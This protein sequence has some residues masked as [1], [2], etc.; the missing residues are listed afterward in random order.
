MRKIGFL[1]P[2]FLFACS[3]APT[4]TPQPANKVSG[5]KIPE[6]TKSRVVTFEGNQVEQ[7]DLD[8]NGTFDAVD[9]DGDGDVDGGDFDGDGEITDFTDLATGLDEPTEAQ[10][11]LYP[12][13]VD[14]DFF[15]EASGE[16]QAEVTTG[17]SVDLTPMFP[18]VMNQGAL[19]SCAAFADAAAATYMRN[20]REKQ[21]APWASP[22]YLYAL[23]LSLDNSKCD[24]GTYI[25]WHLDMLVRGGAPTIDA[26]P[27]SD[28]ACIDHTTANVMSPEQYRIGGWYAIDPLNKD[29]VREA[30]AAGLPVVI[31][32]T[33]PPNFGGWS[34][35]EA[36]GVFKSN[37]GQLD[38]KHGGGHAMVIIGYDDAKSAYRVRNSWGTDWGD[39]GDMWWDYADLDGRKGSYGYVPLELNDDATPFAAVNAASFA[40]TVKGAVGFTK[41]TT[42]G[43]TLGLKTTEPLQLTKVSIDTPAAEVTLDQWI[44]DGYV[45]IPMSAAVSAG[46]ANITIE[47]KLRDGTVVSKTVAAMLTTAM[48]PG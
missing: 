21:S 4:P 17:A 46:A 16:P 18:A 34:G 36:K 11:E 27:Y 38:N 25:N 1:L 41:G 23:V 35:E 15:A 42:H 40:A 26:V 13:E 3:P 14:P 44:Y 24:N 37:D 47:G 28:K 31:G 29:K 19:G 8:G 6:A 45:V 33:L 39:R 22:A 48:D 30:L 32:A 43:V 9:L 5:P 7:Y 12:E 10:T 20:K 2:V